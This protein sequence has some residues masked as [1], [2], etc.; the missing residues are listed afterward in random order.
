[1]EIVNSYD[2]F[3]DDVNRF[4]LVIENGTVYLHWSW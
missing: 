4:W 3:S 1:M 2:S